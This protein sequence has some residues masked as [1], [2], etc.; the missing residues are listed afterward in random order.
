MQNYVKD[1]E[2]KHFEYMRTAEER[3]TRQRERE[4]RTAQREYE[5]AKIREETRQLELRAQVGNQ[6]EGRPAAQNAPR[7]KLPRFDEAHDDIDAFLERFERLA[8][9]QGWE[10]DSWA[11]SLSPLLTGKA[12]G[13]YSSLPVDDSKDYDALKTAILRRYCLTEDG[14]RERFRNTRPERQDTAKQFGAKLEHLFNRWIDLSAIEKD[15]DGLFDLCLREQFITQCDTELCVFLRE[16]SP[17][18][19]EDMVTLA[20]TYIQAHGNSMVKPRPNVK[21]RPPQPK[22]TPAPAS[23]ASGKSAEPTEGLTCYYCKKEGHLKRDCRR[24]KAVREKYGDRSQNSSAPKI[25]AAAISAREFKPLSPAE[26]E[27]VARDNFEDGH[28]LLANG[29]KVPY[30]GA[31]CNNLSKLQNL[32][33]Y[34]GYIGDQP[35]G[36][37]RDSGCSSAAVKRAYV[38]DEQLTGQHSDCVLID[39]TVRRF[40]LAS[41]SVDTPIFK[42][43]LLAMVMKDPVCDLIIGNVPGLV[44]QGAVSQDAC[45]TDSIQDEPVAAAAETRAEERRARKPLKPLVTPDIKIDEVSGDQLRDLQASDESLS[46]LFEHAREKT[47]ITLRNEARVRYATQKGILSRFYFRDNEGAEERIKQIVVPQPL[48]TK[49]MALAHEAIVGGHLGTKKTFDRITANFYWPGIDGDVRR[50]CQSC[51]ICQRTAPKGRTTKIPLGEMPIISTPFDRVAVDIIGPIHPVSEN[52]NRYI[53]TVVDY[54]TRYPEAVP[55]RSIETERIA[56]ALLEVFS[57][58]GFPRE[59]L[60]DQGTQFTSELMAEIARL[61]SMKQLFTTPYNPKCNGLCERM[62]GTLKSMLKKMCQER[63]TDWDRYLPAVLFAYREVPQSSTGFSPFELLYGRKVRGPMDIVKELWSGTPAEDVHNAYQYVVDLRNRLEDTC[64]FARE[65][66]EQSQGKYK[67]HYDRKARKRTFSVGERVYLLLPTDHNK[68]LLQWKGPFPV[69][70][71]I[72]GMD[73][74]IEVHDKKRIY[75]ANLLKRCIERVDPQERETVITTD[76]EDD[77]PTSIAAAARVAV[78]NEET[79]GND[80]EGDVLSFPETERTE[81]YKDVQINPDLSKSRQ[82]EVQC[83]LHEFEDIFSDIPGETNLGEHK[84]ELTTSEPIRVKPYPIPYAKRTTIEEEVQKMLKAGVIEPS[85]SDY[86]SPVV[87]VKKKDG[88]NRFCIDFRKINSVTRFDTEPMDNYEDIIART[89][90]DNIFSKLDFSKG[91]WQIPM[92]ESSK[93]YTAFT[94][95]TGSY[96]FRRNPFGLVNSG[97][98]F[99]RVARKLLA[100]IEH[101]DAYVDDVLPHTQDWETHVTTLR[102][103]FTRVRKAKLTLRPTKCFIGYDNVEFTGHVLGQGKLQMEQDKID[104]IRNAAQPSTKKRVR[105][106]LGLAGFYRRF[107]PEFAQIAHPLTDLTKKGKPNV[108]KWGDKEQRAFDT[109]K[110]AI[111]SSPILRLPDFTKTFTLQCDASDTGLGAVL[112]QEHSDGMFP[113]AYASRKMLQR[114]TNYS[115]TEKECLAIVF[116]IQHFQKYLYGTKFVLETD[117]ASLAYL[118]KAKNDSARV[119]RWALFLQNY[120]FTV[121]YIK[122]K[123]NVGADYLSRM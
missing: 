12:L 5:L 99:N 3:E 113:I 35:V 87:I 33:T 18:T 7:P 116:G 118:H 74:E 84:I 41:I 49:I 61:I 6:P 63:P 65:N 4:E 71:V 42:G 45:D 60:S 56:E 40:P 64:L 93:R 83:L 78:I 114:E 34:M 112:L 66:L 55:L 39:G 9:H 104:K 88:T 82:E 77:A 70:R 21:P 80:A 37:L 59:I 8:T 79:E 81:T 111:T 115:V 10:K 29:S 121:R 117:H 103:L 75:H 22:P 47:I 95:P 52:R 109:L 72:N 120:S 43:P 73:Y 20:E 15:F 76:D 51:D 119:M 67:H 98:A 19:F 89:G 53:L 85:R 23:D 90:N 86:N 36:V 44:T 92:E 107:I 26:A 13:V 48:R 68:L 100:G 123:D 14:F 105:S 28:L 58:I 46:K 96:Q 32:P 17:K 102:E 1:Q 69:T 122:G 27:A 54:A 16:R 31:L 97:S 11:Y 2:R 110:D 25:G 108:V 50:F 62:N 30:V 106:F 91:Y 24:L 94:T 57:R 101:V 38:T